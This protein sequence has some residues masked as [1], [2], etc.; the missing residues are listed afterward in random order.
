VI[1]LR[2]HIVSVAA[3]FLAL[4]VGIVLGSTS[5]SE[6]LLSGLNGQKEQLAT[7]VSQLHAKNSALRSELGSDARFA[8]GVGPLAV[9]GDLDKRTVAL[10]ST[11]GV[12]P[13][14]RKA[15]VSLLSE[16]GAK[17]TAK[18]QL[19]K[20]FSDPSQA[21]RLGDMVTHLI[22]AGASLPT[23]TDPGTLS[24][25]LL[26]DVLL[27][28]PDTNKPQADPEEIGS[29]MAAL[30]GGGF[31]RTSGDVRPAQLAVVL[32]GGAVSGDGAGDR[33]SMLARFATQLD[34][35]GV[36]AVLAGGRGS[37]QG[38]GA[39]GVVRADSAASSILSTVDDVDTASGRVVT[40]LALEE[41]LAGKSG[42][43]GT[44]GNAKAVMPA[45]AHGQ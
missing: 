7:Q 34:R 26:G 18:V 39:V 28:G 6:T 10:V 16:A 4:A 27:L 2:Y 22:P 14:T 20:A 41:Q 1:S 38:T 37:A 23:A 9:H 43:Y 32:T 45:P 15:L 29:A 11:P 42:S 21:D 17:V 25:G 33:A 44:A 40:V 31:L 24:G 19:T 30:T 3:V 8:K 13:D 35:S 5:L 36:G 12:S